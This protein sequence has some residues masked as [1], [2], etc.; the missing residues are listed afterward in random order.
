[1]DSSSES[2]SRVTFRSEDTEPASLSPEDSLSL[3]GWESLTAWV[4]EVPLACMAPPTWLILFLC[5]LCFPVG[6]AP[7]C[8]PEQH[9]ECAEPALGQYW[10]TE[11]V[12]VGEG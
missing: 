11:G 7:F 4:R 3:W 6:D 9:K 2:R 1:M 12:V 8:T 10:G 5:L